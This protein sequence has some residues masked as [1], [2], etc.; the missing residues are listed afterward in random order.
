[1][2]CVPRSNTAPTEPHSAATAS[3]KPK[4]ND[5]C[6]G[7]GA[8][9]IWNHQPSIYSKKSSPNARTRTRKMVFLFPSPPSPFLPNE[10]W[11]M[12]P[13]P[14]SAP[15]PDAP[16]PTGSGSGSGSDG[17]G[18]RP[19]PAGGNDGAPEP[20]EASGYPP[21]GDDEDDDSAAYLG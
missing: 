14:L 7:D 12:P 2:A 3:C 20:A 15:D 9:R 18:S 13:A 10:R 21:P 1:M 17:T 5:R 11:F 8:T 4:S 16:E 6:L 19:A